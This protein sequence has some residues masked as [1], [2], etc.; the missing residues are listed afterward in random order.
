MDHRKIIDG[1]KQFTYNTYKRKRPQS[2]KLAARFSRAPK[3]EGFLKVQK[4]SHA[5]PAPWSYEL[6]IKW[7]KGYKGKGIERQGAL[8]GIEDR[9]GKDR[10]LFKKW[11]HF[12]GGNPEKE[13]LGDGNVKKV[14][15]GRGK[16]D[17]K[18][19]VW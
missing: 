4:H 13:D 2:S 12:K 5:V 1:K 10:R 15:K 6:G 8:V 19:S 18:V 17:M 7:M 9:E 14:K 11:K 16:L 3:C